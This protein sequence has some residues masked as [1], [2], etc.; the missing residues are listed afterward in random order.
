VALLRWSKKYSVGVSSADREHAAFLRS[1]NR[2]HAAMIQGMGKSV[3]GPILRSPPARAR[4]HFASEES[5]M[6]SSNYPRLAAH[7]AEHEIFTRKLDELVT[8]LEEG[9]NSLS[10]LLLPFMREWLADHIQKVDQAYGPWLNEH[11]IH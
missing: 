2:L 8:R 4:D 3:T 11:G 10:I 9:D 1:L 5:M 6:K 7:L